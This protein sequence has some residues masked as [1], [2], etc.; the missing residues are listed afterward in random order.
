MNFYLAFLL[1]LYYFFISFQEKPVDCE[2]VLNVIAENNTQSRVLQIFAS[3]RAVNFFEYFFVP[4]RS[5][6]YDGI[7]S[8]LM[9]LNRKHNQNN[10]NNNNRLQFTAL[11]PITDRRAH[12]QKN[13]FQ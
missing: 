10:N 3:A 11:W 7:K 5:Q 4:S 2:R 13:S 8:I 6:Q 1:L 9:A 12:I